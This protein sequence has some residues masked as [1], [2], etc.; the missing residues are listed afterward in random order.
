MADGEG[1]LRLFMEQMPR[2]EAGA[3]PHD[4]RLAATSGVQGL[5]RSLEITDDQNTISTAEFAGRK[6]RGE[7]IWR[8]RFEARPPLSADTSWIELLGTRVELGGEPSGI[9]SWTEPL[10]R[11]DPAQRHLWERVATRDDFHDPRAA[12]DATVAALVAVG[13]LRTDDPVIGDAQTAANALDA[14]QGTGSS[15]PQAQDEARQPAVPKTTGTDLSPAAPSPWRS[16]LARL[17]RAGGPTGT[18]L[19]SA[20]TPPFDGV[21]VMVT[22]IESRPECFAIGAEVVPGLSVGLP[23]RTLHHHGHLIWWAVDD[24]GNYFL[25][26]QGS[27]DPGASRAHGQLLFRPALDP[28]STWVDLMPTAT[29]TRGVIR[30]PLPWADSCP[31]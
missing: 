19:V 2:L 8:G 17:G 24:R 4:A 23:Y 29:S 25:G 9:Q 16:L 26:E 7:Q 10:P 18:V 31:E 1:Y 28:E 11:Q 20:V 22:A 3:Y 13:A 14:S 15:S 6:R 21:R 5:P 12:L 30:V 27:W